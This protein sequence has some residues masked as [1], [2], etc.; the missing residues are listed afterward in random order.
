MSCADELYVI[1]WLL[2]VFMT[3][4]ARSREDVCLE[5]GLDSSFWKRKKNYSRISKQYPVLGILRSWSFPSH[6]Q[7]QTAA[8]IKVN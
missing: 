2:K 7:A 6:L 3:N 5:L 8:K 1:I 4:C